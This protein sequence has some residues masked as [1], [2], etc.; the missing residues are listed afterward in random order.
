MTQWSMEVGRAACRLDCS[1]ES[2]TF[3]KCMTILESSTKEWWCSGA[4]TADTWYHSTPADRLLPPIRHTCR[5]SHA[6][7]GHQDSCLQSIAERLIIHISLPS[8]SHTTCEYV[9]V[10]KSSVLPTSLWHSQRCQLCV[11]VVQHLSNVQPKST[12]CNATCEGGTNKCYA[13]YTDGR[14]PHIAANSQTDSKVH[15]KL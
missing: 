5:E 7:G 6:Y 4:S 10:L 1:L 13:S 14:S 15:C 2:M 8:K 9:L 3:M 11:K 12:C